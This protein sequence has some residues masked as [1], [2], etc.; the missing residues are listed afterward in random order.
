M[1][2][3]GE[4]LVSSYLRYIRQCDF[5]ETNLPTESQGEIDVVGLNMSKQQVYVC[6]VAIHIRG[7]QYTT[8]DVKNGIKTRRPDNVQ[9]L[10]D[11]FSRGIKHA[12]KHWNQYDRHFMFWSPII[13]TSQMRHLEEIKANVK[14]QYSVAIEFIVNERFQ[15]C[16]A[17]L[18]NYAADKTFEFLCPLMRLM[19][20]EEH[21]DQHLKKLTHMR[22]HES[23]STL[24]KESDKGMDESGPATVTAPATEFSLTGPEM[25][26]LRKKAKLTQSAVA[27]KL[28]MKPSSSAAISDW[29]TE[30]VKVPAKHHATLLSLYEPVNT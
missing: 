24:T 22:G 18:R 8:N 21:I 1:L 25:K 7:L 26:A 28:G 23:T 14:E 3:V 6:E 19:Q 2:N 10:T 5:I 20:I 15:A 16:L 30:R 17:E 13:N 9:R 11:K 27:V 12:C 29:E 4:Q